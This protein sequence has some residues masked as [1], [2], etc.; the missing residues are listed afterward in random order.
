[1]CLQ[2]KR[3][4]I[5]YNPAKGLSDLMLFKQKLQQITTDYTFIPIQN[6]SHTQIRNIMLQSK[7]YIDFGNHPGKDRIPREAAMC[8]CCIITG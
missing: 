7:I 6:M 2:N 8:G 3:N 1:M 4:N 5:L